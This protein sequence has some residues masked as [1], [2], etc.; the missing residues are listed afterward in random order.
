MDQ[1]RAARFALVTAAH[2]FVTA[3]LPFRDPDSSEALRSFLRELSTSL[4]PSTELEAVLLRTLRVVERGTGGRLPTMIERYLAAVE[5]GATAHTAFRDCIENVLRYRGIGNPFVQRAIAM[6]EDRYSDSTTTA[7]SIAETLRVRRNTLAVAF[8]VQVG[9][10]LTDYLRN[11]RLDHAAALL[12]SS[13]KSVKEVWVFVGYNHASNFDRDF[14]DRFANSP[15]EYRARVI[16]NVAYPD[17]HTL[18]SDGVEPSAHRLL[19]RRGTVLIIDDDDGTRRTLSTY[20]KL[21]GYDA[22]VADTGRQ[23]L[24]QAETDSPDLLLLDYHLPDISGVEC[25]RT[26]RGKNINVPAII[27]S[28]DLD[29]EL[30]VDECRSVGASYLSKLCALEDVVR[31]LEAAVN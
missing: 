3:S 11:V 5:R 24:R 13:D 21:E 9:I 20:L 15:R 12:A 28:A 2:H 4:V 22:M 1:R 31:A 19:R 26:L 27:F 10:N 17:A 16:R 29:L 7:K 8:N 18:E 25:L 6:V 30:Q 14:K 23:G